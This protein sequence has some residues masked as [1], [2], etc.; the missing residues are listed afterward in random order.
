[1]TMIKTVV[2]TL[3]VLFIIATMFIIT[4]VFIDG[5]LRPVF[6]ALEPNNTKGL[7]DDQYSDTLDNIQQGKKWIFGVLF[8]VPFVFLIYRLLYKKE[9]TTVFGG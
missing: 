5:N 9:D 3:I 1:M 2:G 4:T 7:L 6:D 8:L